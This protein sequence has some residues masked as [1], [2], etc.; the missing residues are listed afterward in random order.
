[1]KK[2]AW[3]GAVLVFLVT[4]AFG[5]R[6]YLVSELRVPVLAKL[7]DPA[8]AQFRNERV[9]GWAVGGSILCGEVNA[10]NRMGGYVG[11]VPFFAAAGIEADIA[12]IGEVSEV[13]V[14]AQCSVIDAK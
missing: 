1:M 4:T 11:F 5:Y 9:L 6:S 2:F 14:E 7:N 8:S 13:V 12:T 10:K 3:A